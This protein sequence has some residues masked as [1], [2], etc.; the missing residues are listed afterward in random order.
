MNSLQLDTLEFEHFQNHYLGFSIEFEMNIF[1]ALL[2]PQTWDSEQLPTDDV[3]MDECA[4]T[5][6][7]I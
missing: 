7:L 1:I 6:R 2:Q 5:L 4:T 3:A